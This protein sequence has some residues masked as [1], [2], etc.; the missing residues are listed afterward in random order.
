MKFKKQGWLSAALVFYLQL[1]RQFKEL[2]YTYETTHYNPKYASF[3]DEPF[4]HRTI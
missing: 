4:R 1:E 2:K 3:G